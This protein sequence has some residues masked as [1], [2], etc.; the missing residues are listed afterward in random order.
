M[1]AAVFWFLF[2][3]GLFLHTRGFTE[4]Q[5]LADS[6]YKPMKDHRPAFIKYENISYLNIRF[7]CNNKTVTQHL[8]H[9]LQYYGNFGISTILYFSTYTMVIPCYMGRYL[10]YYDTVV[11]YMYPGKTMLNVPL[12]WNP[13]Y[14]FYVNMVISLPKKV[15]DYHIIFKKYY[16]VFL[17]DPVR[18][19]KHSYIKIHLPENQN[20][21]GFITKN[22]FLQT[23]H[24][25]CR[26]GKKNSL[27]SPLLIQF[28]YLT[29]LADFI[30][31]SKT[32]TLVINGEIQVNLNQI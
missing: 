23:K 7:T 21:L 14:L 13:V 20:D 3:L 8:L 4:V 1:A 24:L 28:I 11:F 5:Q 18:G 27:V 32:R 26:W 17:S 10:I 6:C 12:P 29:L 22:N 30:S 19:S 31:C 25:I 16:S 9:N 15:K 2:P